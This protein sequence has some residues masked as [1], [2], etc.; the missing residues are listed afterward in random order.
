MRVITFDIETSNTFDE[1]ES[2]EPQALDLSVVCVHDSE[3]NEITHYYQEDLNKLWPIL[4]S[5]DILVGYNNDHFDTPLLNKYYEGDLT[6]IKSVD[7]MNEIK[8]VFGK[9]VKLDNVVQATL[10]EAKSAHGLQAIIWWR[11]GEKE[12]VV[13]YCKQDVLVTR[14]LYDFIKENGFVYIPQD[15]EKVKVE[16]NSS[17]WEKIEGENGAAP[18]LGF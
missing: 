7:L 12:K 5:A 3:T 16:I 14:K 9:R 6:Q 18:T 10:G 2:P 1:V 11:N 8:K 13:E 4:E 17:D 15:N